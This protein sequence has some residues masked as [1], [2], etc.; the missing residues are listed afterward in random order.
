MSAIV[1]SLVAA[2]SELKRAQE[3]RN[4]LI[5]K[6]AGE[7]MSRREIARVTGLSHQRVSQIVDEQREASP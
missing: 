5:A 7:G 6:A 4:R 1:K 2:V 3:K